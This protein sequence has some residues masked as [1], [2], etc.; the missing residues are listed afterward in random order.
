M[1]I[2]LVADAVTSALRSLADAGAVDSLDEAATG[3]D[4][5]GP[6]RIGSGLHP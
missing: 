2:L 1:Q 4:C 5:R 6:G 3:T